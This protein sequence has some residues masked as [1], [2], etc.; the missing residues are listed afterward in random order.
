MSVA[1]AAA[2]MGATWLGSGYALSL[3]IEK[4]ISDPIMVAKYYNYFSLF[5]ILIIGATA[6]QR[7]TKFI[8]FLMPLWAGFCLF[9][10]WLV[11]PN[12]AA[13]FGILIVC[14]ALAIMTYMQ[15][16][17]HERFGIAGPGNRV[18]KIFM[19]LIILQCV[20]VFINSAAIFP[21][22]TQFNGVVNSE[23]NNINLNQEIVSMNSAGGLTAKVVDIASA[24]LQIAISSIL[25][26]IKCLVSIGFFAVILYS[27]FPW[28][29][30]SGGPY[31]IA[32]LMIVQFA[33]WG[34]YLLF[35]VTLFY[36]PSPDPGW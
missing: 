10:G 13:G 28:I 36:K 17:V 25:L 26:L 32:F 8:S 4:V 30:T 5:T 31:G 33:I 6:S 14:C 20:V 22:E 11:Y 15:E 12:M 24:S 29:V 27:I 9:A 3:G 7:D 35:I 34:M 1:Y 23:Y 19:F 16:T 21:S 2:G 18:V